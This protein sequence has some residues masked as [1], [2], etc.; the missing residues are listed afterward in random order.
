MKKFLVSLAAVSMLTGASLAVA[1]DADAARRQ[2]IVLNQAEIRTVSVQGE[3]VVRVAPDQA[4]VTMV[5]RRRAEAL[6]DAHN[7][8]QGDLQRFQDAVVKAGFGRD[9]VRSGGLRYSPEY[10]YQDGQ[11][12]RAV[13][14]VAE[15]TVILRIDKISDVPRVMELAIGAGAA[16]VHPVQYRVSNLEEKQAEARQLAMRAAT[17]RATE[18]ATGFNAKLGHI[19]TIQEHGV[20]MYAVRQ[21]SRMMAMAAD[22]MGSGESFA[23]ID[24]DAVEVRASVSATFT[25]K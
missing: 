10:V 17:Q 4:T 1:S 23:Q 7:D 2:E 8:V 13:G 24:P 21:E 3:G 19:Q 20:A 14:F 11:A 16:E 15:S 9:L 12:P 6:M 22:S 25:L 18:L 5:F